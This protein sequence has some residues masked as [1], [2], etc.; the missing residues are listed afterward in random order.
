MLRPL[1]YVFLFH[2]VA[3]KP[4]ET[5]ETTYPDVQ[6]VGAM[7]NVMWKGQLHGTLDLDT[8]ADKQNLYGLGPVEYLTGEILINNGQVYISRVLSDS[9]MTVEKTSKVKAPFFVTA[10]V[11]EWRQVTL[12]DTIKQIQQL[13]AYVDAITKNLKRPF[14][15]KLSGTVSSAQIHI[16]NL[17]K[18]TTVRSPDEAHQGQVKYVLDN[19]PS[20]IIGF[21]ST[22]HKGIFT[23]HD[24]FL[25]LHLITKDEQKM[26]HLDMVT[27][28]QDMKLFLPVR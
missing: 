25:H 23:H 19:E 15:L 6:V 27:L 17:P 9:M 28:G 5:L 10:T 26:G 18:G 21:F 4:Q 3:C 2:L 13:E 14:A 7:K 24:S 11:S 16:Q 8:I 22:Q 1:V 20:D 12:P